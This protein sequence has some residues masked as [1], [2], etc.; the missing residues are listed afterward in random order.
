MNQEPGCLTGHVSYT[1][2]DHQTDIR[3]SMNYKPFSELETGAIFRDNEH[4][5][6]LLMKADRGNYGVVLSSI[7]LSA[8][9]LPRGKLIEY[10][11]NECVI[12]EL[13]DA[14]SLPAKRV[15][16]VDPRREFWKEGATKTVGRGRAANIEIFAGLFLYS[17]FGMG[18]YY[19]A[20]ENEI[21]WCG[22]TEARKRAEAEGVL[23]VYYDSKDWT[24]DP[25]LT[26]E[27]TEAQRRHE[28][29]KAAEKENHALPG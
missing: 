14:V 7:W 25:K 21:F 20:T 27:K 24:K 29:A 8:G 1:E 17:G 3:T 5:G 16:P 28:Q 15:D 13:E 18:N 12:E 9:L 2:K 4:R 6:L 22:S 19:S 10:S 11:P 26:F 23:Y